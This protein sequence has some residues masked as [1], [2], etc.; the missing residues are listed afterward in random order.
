VIPPLVV[1]ENHDLPIARLTVT[2]L[3]GAIADPADRPGEAAFAAEL[4]RRAAGG[5]SRADLDVA[6]ESLGA[7]LDV[8]A[9]FDSITWDLEV[10]ARNLQPAVA[11]LADVILRPDLPEEEAEKLRRENHAALDEL[12]DDDSSIARRF[13]ARQLF[14]DHPYGRPLWGTDASIDL[15]GVESARRWL[16]RSL[17]SGNLLFGAAGDVDPAELSSL[18][19]RR[20]GALRPG[21]APA[22]CPPDPAFPE[23]L[24]L[25][26]VDKPERTQSQILLGHPAPRWADP[27]FL[28]LSVAATAFGG[29]FTARLMTEVRVKRGLSYGASARLGQGRGARS[30]AV[31][32][33]PSLDQTPETLALVLRLWREWIDHGLTD[34][35]IAFA[36]GYLA[37]SFAFH[38]ATPE[39]RLDLALALRVCDL[40]L[41][42][43]H[44]AV[45]R[46]QAVTVGEVRDAM[47]RRLRPND[48]AITIVTTANALRPMLSR[49]K[50]LPDLEIETL[51][52][53]SY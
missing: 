32:V 3:T 29:T 2:A 26:L 20:F 13:F 50:D 16:A 43:A 1:E 4:A 14:G 37:S 15:L 47:A 42:Y 40:P 35:E 46:I 5:R 22:A 51:P 36:R 27:D 39:D 25:L 34:D 23:G 52:Y 30:L 18:L 11:L 9:D 6:L 21:G 41:D 53:D 17:A 19:Q 24:R 10:L 28:P 8:H 7:E 48:L 33:F 49:Q 38:V 31:T 12:R 45:R 44:T